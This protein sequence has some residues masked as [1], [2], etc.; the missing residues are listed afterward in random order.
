M[1]YS[2]AVCIMR[3]QVDLNVRDVVHSIQCIEGQWRNMTKEGLH[4]AYEI[5]QAN[6]GESSKKEDT[7]QCSV[8]ILRQNM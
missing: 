2:C 7:R 1:K 3:P 5:V 8:N 6:I 4:V